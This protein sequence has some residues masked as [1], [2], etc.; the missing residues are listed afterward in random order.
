MSHKPIYIPSVVP[1]P[2]LDPAVA[3]YVMSQPIMQLK[4]LVVDRMRYDAW[5]TW[6][7]KEHWTEYQKRR[8]KCH[9]TPNP[10]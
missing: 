2:M 3:S 7:A 10:E 8:K 4:E 5:R 6:L 1:L 9:P